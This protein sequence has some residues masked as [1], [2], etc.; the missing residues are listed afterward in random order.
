MSKKNMNRLHNYKEVTLIE[1]VF[2]NKYQVTE[3]VTVPA[4]NY[5]QA[6]E[7]FLEGRGDKVDVNTENVYF[8]YKGEEV[9]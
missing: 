7:L 2:E 6:L 9:S 3:E 8:T 4:T 1:Y 5:Q